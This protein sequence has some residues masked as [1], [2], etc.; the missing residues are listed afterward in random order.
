MNT[1]EEDPLNGDV[2]EDKEDPEKGGAQRDD[3]KLK[4]GCF[5]ISAIAVVVIAILC[6]L[7]GVVLCLL[8]R[9]GIFTDEDRTMVYVLAGFKFVMPIVFIVS[10][11][12]MFSFGLWL[13]SFFTR[14]CAIYALAAIFCWSRHH[15][16]IQY[17]LKNY[18]WFDPKVPAEDQEFKAHIILVVYA[19]SLIPYIIAAAVACSVAEQCRKYVHELNKPSEEVNE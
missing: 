1:E 9:A 7:S 3:E 6:F 13:F 17:F 12:T 16:N 11:F 19:V 10:Y 18:H 8:N 15:F 2:N 4:D 14:M 5:V